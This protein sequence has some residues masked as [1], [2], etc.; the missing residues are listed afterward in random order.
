MER[1]VWTQRQINFEIFKNNKS[2]IGLN[3]TANKLYLLSKLLGLKMLYLDFV[4]FKKL[5]K[6]RY[7]NETKSRILIERK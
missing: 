1:I 4:H 5:P 7:E 2:K 3:T 6:Y